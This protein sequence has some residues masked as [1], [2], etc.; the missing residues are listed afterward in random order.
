MLM[1][2]LDAWGQ[3]AHDDQGRQVPKTSRGGAH[4]HC[5]VES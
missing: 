5:A 1:R 3:E 2:L 4:L